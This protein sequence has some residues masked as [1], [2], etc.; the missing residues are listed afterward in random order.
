[1]VSRRCGECGA[2]FVWDSDVGSGICL[3][4]GV[5]EDPNQSVLYAS[6]VE[7]DQQGQND[8]WQRA[9]TTASD[10]T[11]IQTSK[12]YHLPGQSAEVY[13]LKNKVR[14]PWLQI[15]KKGKT[16]FNSLLLSTTLECNSYSHIGNRNEARDF[17]PCIKIP[18]AVR[19]SN[20]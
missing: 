11:R 10:N 9:P 20:G 6:H 19:S 1:M 2:D 14:R 7:Q 17:G 18:N 4:C 13:L 5:L 3:T 12:G 8:P 15:P 16:W